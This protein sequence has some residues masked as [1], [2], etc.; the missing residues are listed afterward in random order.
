MNRHQEA[1]KKDPL[2]ELPTIAKC[3][4]RSV[5]VNDISEC[6]R[7]PKSAPDVPVGT[8]RKT[9]TEKQYTQLCKKKISCAIEKT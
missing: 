6:G 9:D 2:P 1:S 7:V 5:D 3:Q 8:C 4:T